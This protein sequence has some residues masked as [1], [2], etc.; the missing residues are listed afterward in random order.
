MMGTDRC[1]KQRRQP[2]QQEKKK[3]HEE[4]LL[5]VC[6]VAPIAPICT[7]PQRAAAIHASLHSKVSFWIATK[8]THTR[9]S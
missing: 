2:E 9:L 7:N 8:S 3:L 5:H 1:S 6:W 4:L